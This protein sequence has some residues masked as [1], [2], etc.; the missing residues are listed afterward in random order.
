MSS[1]GLL[2]QAL[3]PDSKPCQLLGLAEV[4]NCMML[5]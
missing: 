3:E 5:W 1:D 2:D 4:S